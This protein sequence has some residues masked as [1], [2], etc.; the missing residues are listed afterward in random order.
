M[1]SAIN[2]NSKIYFIQEVED[3]RY[4]LIFG[5]GIFGQELQNGNII[6]VSILEQIEPQET[7]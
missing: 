6:E 7:V 1:G 5:D 3:E 4:E 2:G